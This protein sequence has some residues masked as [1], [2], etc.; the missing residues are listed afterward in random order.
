[1]FLVTPVQSAPQ[2]SIAGTKAP[3]PYAT[4]NLS[5]YGPDPTFLFMDVQYEAISITVLTK[6]CDRW[7]INLWLSR[8]TK[9]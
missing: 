2:V 8:I 3:V 5:G 9:T 6:E 4:D 1:M 7:Q